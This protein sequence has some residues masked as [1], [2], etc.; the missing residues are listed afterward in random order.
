MKR[1][2]LENAEKG[3]AILGLIFF[4]GAFDIGLTLETGP[5]VPGLLRTAVRY[6]VWLTAFTLICLNWKDALRTINGDRILWILIPIILLSFIW[7]DNLEFTL[8]N[9]REVW[10]MSTFGL[11]FATRFSLK[12][13]VRLVAWTFAIAIL[14]SIL[15]ALVLP[16][17]AIHTIDHPGAWRG[18]YDYKNTF[19]SMMLISSLAFFLLPIDNPRHRLYKRVGVGVSLVM[20]LLSTSKTSLVIYFLLILILA[21]YRN[22]RWQG[23]IS[24]IF[25]DITVLLLACSA[26]VVASYWVTLLTGLG[27]D[28]T[29][30]G[31]TIMWSYILFRLNERPWLGF[32]RGVFWEPGSKYPIEAGQALGHGFIPPHAHNGFID[33]TLDVG[34]IGL[35]LFLISYFTAFVRALKRAY[36]TKNP[37][38]VWPLG[39][40]IF[41]AMNNMTESQL[42]R[43]ANIY[44]VLY[45][46]VVLSVKPT[47]QTNKLKNT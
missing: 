17:I 25:V 20:M 23:K 35:S 5:L 11:Y 42:L 15:L 45:I 2:H 29:L 3:F 21:F 26:T 14:A 38:D 1:K 36:A 44:W 32:G 22:F 39:F 7:S 31:R 41:L 34:F 46:A 24:V 4:T 33:F 18:I 6:F 19:G 30:T 40:L 8:K 27:K 10:Q 37:E 12:E 47:R 28:P 9:S 43:L 16:D 13:Q